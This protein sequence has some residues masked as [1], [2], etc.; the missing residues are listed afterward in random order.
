VLTALG[1]LT[2]ATIFAPSNEA[3]EEL[4]AMEGFEELAATE[5]F[6]ESLL[7]YHVV[8]APLLSDNIT[9][10]PLFVPTMLQDTMYSNV[11]GG[12]VIGL[13]LSGEG[14]DA[15]AQVISGLAQRSNITEADIEVS[16]GYVHIIDS[17]LTLPENV[18]TT[19]VAANLTALAGA[20]IFADLVETL[21]TAEDITVFAPTTEAFEAIAS[22]LEDITPEMVA[23]ILS[24]HVVAGNVTYSSLLENGT[25][26]EAM[27]GNML[28]VT[29]IDGTVFINSARVVATDVLV[30]GG[31][32]HVID[33][34]LNPESVNAP[35]AEEEESPSN[36]E[37]ATAGDIS[38]ITNVVTQTVT[39]V[40]EVPTANPVAE[41]AAD[42]AAGTSTE[43]GAATMP[44]GAIGVAAL[45]GGIAVLAQL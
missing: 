20:V 27:D 9:A 11:T 16:T 24:Y 29:I 37:G 12:Q 39:S 32:V 4:M 10:S 34:V 14:D 13:V 23:E 38:E 22:A 28:N 42:G 41:D 2:N 21:D 45:F 3:F 35:N 15:S 5:G 7:M 31:V 44:T 26:L 43:A 30:S 40:I 25:M 33:A 1:G 18:S 17:V 8:E 19:A 36:F 6:I